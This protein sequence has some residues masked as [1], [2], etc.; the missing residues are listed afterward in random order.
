MSR[1]S[2]VPI[3][4]KAMARVWCGGMREG[5]VEGAAVSAS[6]ASLS[7]VSIAGVDVDGEAELEGVEGRDEGWRCDSVRSI[8]EKAVWGFMNL[9]GSYIR[10]PLYE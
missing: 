6:V 3:R 10:R 1:W 7:S 8:W 2:G 9:G 5:D 4:D